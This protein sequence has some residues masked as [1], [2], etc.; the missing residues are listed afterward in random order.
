MSYWYYT[1]YIY[2]NHL[3]DLVFIVGLSHID[4]QMHGEEG[5]II[6]VCFFNAIFPHGFYGNA[7]VYLSAIN[8]HIAYVG[9]KFRK[10]ICSLVNLHSLHNRKVHGRN[11]PMRATGS[12]YDQTGNTIWR[13]PNRKLPHVRLYT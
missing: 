4:T 8:F 10:I 13:L 9:D 6:P 1:Y 3:R 11:Y 12:L 5:D 7:F 2:I